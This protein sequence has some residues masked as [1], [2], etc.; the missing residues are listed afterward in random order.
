MCST[1]C[2]SHMQNNTFLFI[3]AHVTRF[4]YLVFLR[5]PGQSALLS[6]H[7]ANDSANIES[8]LDRRRAWPQKDQFTFCGKSVSHF[9]K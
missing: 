4:Y 3:S 7:S 8:I 9:V 5:N 1:V 2:F 6:L